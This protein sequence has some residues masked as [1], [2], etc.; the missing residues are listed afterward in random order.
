MNGTLTY[1]EQPAD[2]ETGCDTLDSVLAVLEVLSD[3]FDFYLL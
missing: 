2:I 3:F 1:P